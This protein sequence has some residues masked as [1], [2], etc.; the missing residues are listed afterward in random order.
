LKPQGQRSADAA[1]KLKQKGDTAVRRKY[2]RICAIIS[3]RII[4]Y[5]VDIVLCSL[6]GRFQ[7]IEAVTH[8]KLLIRASLRG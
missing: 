4:Q 1:K 2:A 7:G 5:I 8:L 6:R 3:Q